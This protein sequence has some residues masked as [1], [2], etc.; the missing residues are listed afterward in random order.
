MKKLIGVLA[1]LLLVG[2]AWAQCNYPYYPV[3]EGWVWT[4]KNS[5]T[6][7][8]YTS[9]QSKVSDSGFTMALNFGKTVVENRWSCNANGLASLEYGG[10]NSSAQNQQIKMETISSK[11]VAIPAR[12]SVGSTWEYSYTIKGTMPSQGGTMTGDSSVSNKVVGEETVKVPAGTFRAFKVESTFTTKMNMSAS[13][14][15]MSLPPTSF[16]S[17]S[18]YAQGVGMVKSVSQVGTTELISLKK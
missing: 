17:T 6:G 4:Y 9:A 2:A 16:K 8:T 14:K 11:G 5:T 7:K 3:R 10:V 13:G 15:A 18:W 12:L 1:G